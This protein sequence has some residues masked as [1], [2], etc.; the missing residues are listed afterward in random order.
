MATT[1]TVNIHP[2]PIAKGLG[3]AFHVFLDMPKEA[4]FDFFINKLKE[5]KSYSDRL[6]L[7]GQYA[8]YLHDKWTVEGLLTILNEFNGLQRITA[9]SRFPFYLTKLKL[10][11]YL[12][13]VLE[14]FNDPYDRL[15]ALRNM[16]ND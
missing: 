2:T 12:I 4:K 8:G 13:K 14:D 1:T 16:C 5:T 6:D 10:Q 7:L 11:D 15:Y 3:I 9:L